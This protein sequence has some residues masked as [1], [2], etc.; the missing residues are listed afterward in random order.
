MAFLKTR[1]KLI[2]RQFSDSFIP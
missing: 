1:F 2:V